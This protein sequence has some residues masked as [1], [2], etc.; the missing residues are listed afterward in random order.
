M[1][2]DVQL[3]RRIC[4]ERTQ[5]F[6]GLQQK[7]GPFQDHPHAPRVNILEKLSQCPQH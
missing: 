6:P 4:G 3:A 7:L 2:R 1:P 5:R